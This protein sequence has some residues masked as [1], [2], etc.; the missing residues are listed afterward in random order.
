MRKR[1]NK[2]KICG[3]HGPLTV[4]K[5]GKIQAISLK[6]QTHWPFDLG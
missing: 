5:K 2:S 6:A 4:K 3:R 1:E